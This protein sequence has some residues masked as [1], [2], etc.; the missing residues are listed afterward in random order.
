MRFQWKLIFRIIGLI[1]MIT[2]GMMLFPF[3]CAVYFHEP[4]TAVGMA[5]SGSASV[6]S[7]SFMF[8]RFKNAGGNMRA[9]DSYLLVIMTWIFCSFFGAWPY[10]WSGQV[11]NFIDA[12]FEAISGYTTTGATVVI[13]IY[14][15]PSLL[16]WKAL[17]HWLGGMGILVFMITLLPALGV[18]GQTIASAEA[19]GPDI[20]KLAPRAQD[21]A[22]LL[23]LIYISLSVL[24]FLFLWIGSDMSAFEAVIS[25]MGS[26]ST[27]G[28]NLH[29]GGVS[30]YNS[31]YVEFVLAIFTVLSSLNY[32]LY[33]SLIKRDRDN[34]RQNTEVKMYGA[35]LGIITVLVSF[36]LYV[37]DV[38]GTVAE[39]LRH[40]FFQVAAFMSTAGFTLDNYTHWP[41]FSK[42]FFILML[43]VGGC[44]AS[45]GGGVKLVRFIIVLKS[46]RQSIHKRLHPRAV[47]T[48]KMD[49]R[50][51]QE[52]IQYNTYSFL[53]LFVV[54]FLLS[55]L[56]VSLDDNG[57]E[58]TFSSV[59]SVLS[60]TGIFLG[61]SG[62][63]G[64]FAIF[65]EPMR[66]FFAGL[67]IVGRLELFTV[68]MVFFPSFWNPERT[69]Q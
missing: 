31:F 36:D 65:S 1:L 29:P 22:K 63:T 13:D 43:I 14:M 30:Y 48:M 16:L 54:T 34:L 47:S 33:V 56:I 21:M 66:L 28:L 41:S 40:A 8:F 6:A 4:Q 7:G 59:L 24:E 60:T 53:V 57:L 27:A 39:C 67:M 44:A 17:T 55:S 11:P 37:H 3:I 69:K 38:Y 51:V 68:F 20:S 12:I 50:P 58:T 10:F 25:T 2:G 5:I 61:E 23:Y 19:P 9:R 32:A 64:N 26:I 15:T 35:M 45:T 62:A 18:S 52:R 46:I 42:M 49:G